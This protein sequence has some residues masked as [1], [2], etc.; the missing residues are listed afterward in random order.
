MSKEIVYTGDIIVAQS[1]IGLLDGSEMF[2]IQNPYFNV[3]GIQK[4]ELASFLTVASTTKYGTILKTPHIYVKL[5]AS[6]PFTN[7]FSIGWTARRGQKKD[8]YIHRLYEVEA[9]STKY[10]H[11]L[12]FSPSGEM[13]ENDKKLCVMDTQFTMAMDVLLIAKILNIDLSTY[14]DLKDNTKFFAKFCFD[15]NKA[16]ND[17]LGSSKLSPEDEI[18]ISKDY[19]NGFTT[20][21]L[22][23]SKDKR[24]F[25]IKDAGKPKSRIDT[26]W[27]KFYETISSNGIDSMLSKWKCVINDNSSAV[28]S[29][30]L[31]DYLKPNATERTKLFDGRIAVYQKLDS[32]NKNFNPKIKDFLYA[33]RCLGPK[34]FE[35][36]TEHNFATIWGA[37]EDDPGMTKGCVQSGCIF[38]CPQL[39]FKYYKAGTPGTQWR[40]EQFATKIALGGGNG[41][42]DNE[43]VGAFM[44]SDDGGFNNGGDGGK[45]SDNETLATPVKQDEDDGEPIGDGN[46]KGKKKK[47]Q[48]IKQLKQFNDD[49]EL[50]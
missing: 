19:I 4:I 6:R 29:I 13:D 46:F 11:K 10:N 37:T 48:R 27:N 1:I 30:R 32:S 17:L 24:Y 41:G 42:A 8:Y 31:V 9:I 34:K 25:A 26:I 43:D 45:G 50:E 20:P 3:P 12:I 14:K 5:V 7:R 39:D 49:E 22:Y 16:L 23:M 44:S 2:C 21:L 33:Q 35:Y 18:K 15:I 40:V 28:P 38:M 47:S 36:I